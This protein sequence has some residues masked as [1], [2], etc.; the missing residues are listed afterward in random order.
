VSLFDSPSQ[1]SRAPLNR[2]LYGC[3]CF[4]YRGRTLGS[5]WVKSLLTDF[6]PKSGLKLVFNVNIVYGNLKSENSQNYGQKPQLNCT[7]LNSASGPGEGKAFSTM[8]LNP[9]ARNFIDA[10]LFGLYSIWYIFYGAGKF[11]FNIFGGIFYF[12]RTIFSTASLPHLRFHCADRCRDRT[13]DRC[14]WCI[15]S[16]TL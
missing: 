4:L 13:Q 7:F 3:V 10:K 11:F 9:L 5:I 6:T 8:P 15:G 1:I 2:T 16:Q 14:N 12:F